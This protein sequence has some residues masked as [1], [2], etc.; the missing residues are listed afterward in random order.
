MKRL[1]KAS[2]VL[3]IVIGTPTPLIGWALMLY[4]LYLLGVPVQRRLSLILLKLKP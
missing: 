3:L 4:G 2:G 1:K